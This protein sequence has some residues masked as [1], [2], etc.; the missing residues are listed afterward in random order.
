MRQLTS[1]T[2]PA[3]AGIA[4]AAMCVALSA[5]MTFCVSRQ[6]SGGLPSRTITLTPRPRSGW[7]VAPRI[8]SWEMA[9]PAV[10]PLFVARSERLRFC[11]EM[12]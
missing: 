5:M 1:T 6:L 7:S 10:P 3:V 2:I 8:L 12:F 9:K 4:V 11:Q